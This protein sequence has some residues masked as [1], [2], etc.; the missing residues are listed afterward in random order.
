MKKKKKTCFAFSRDDWKSFEMLKRIWDGYG[1]RAR[2]KGSGQMSNH[3]GKLVS[4]E[5]EEVPDFTC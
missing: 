2:E 1:M 4:E 5:M 3:K